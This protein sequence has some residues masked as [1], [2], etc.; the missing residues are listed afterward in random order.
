MINLKS[1]ENE[2]C[3]LSLQHIISKVVTLACEM[4]LDKVLDDQPIA[5]ADLAKR[6]LDS[7]GACSRGRI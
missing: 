2:L 1:E 7:C 5:I 3:F 4:H 6:L